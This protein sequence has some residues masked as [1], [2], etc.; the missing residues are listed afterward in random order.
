[1]SIAADLHADLVRLEHKLDRQFRTLLC[2]MLV[3]YPAIFVAIIGLYF[4]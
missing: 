4:K 1:M 3:G 2:I